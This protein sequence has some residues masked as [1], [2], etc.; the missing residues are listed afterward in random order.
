MVGEVLVLQMWI[1]HMAEEPGRC[2][3][4]FSIFFFFF[5]CPS[6]LYLLHGKMFPNLILGV[7]HRRVNPVL[8]NVYGYKKPLRPPFSWRK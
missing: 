4:L 6:I 5:F 3:F 7:C 2:Q 8:A 1:L